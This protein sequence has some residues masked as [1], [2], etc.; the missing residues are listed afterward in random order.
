MKKIRVTREVWLKL[1]PIRLVEDFEIISDGSIIIV[2]PVE[3]KGLLSR[4]L[5]FL[6]IVPP[7]SYKRFIL[8]KTGGKIWLMCDGSKSIDDIIKALMRESG[9]SRRNIEL[10]VYNYINMLVSKGLIALIPPEDK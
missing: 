9:M 8:D 6:S 2:A 4:V 7:P 5:R 1:K 10:A 3:P